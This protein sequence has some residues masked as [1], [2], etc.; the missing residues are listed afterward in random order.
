MK[1]LLVLIISLFITVSSVNA[2]EFTIGG[3]LDVAA[4]GGIGVGPSVYCGI[5]FVK[6]GRKA[7]MGIRPEISVLIGGS[8]VIPVLKL[9]LLFT[10]EPNKKFSWGLGPGICTIGFTSVGPSLDVFFG[11]KAGPGKI[12]INPALD[13]CFIFDSDTVFPMIMLGVGYQYTFK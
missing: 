2:V 8:D 4:S 3:K 6:L 7:K 12:V 10:F 1:K 11:I 9:P 13:Y 5:D